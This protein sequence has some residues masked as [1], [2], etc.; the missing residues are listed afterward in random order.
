[1]CK[2]LCHLLYLAVALRL[3]M[4][5]AVCRVRAQLHEVPS[6]G[7]CTGDST[8]HRQEQAGPGFVPS[9]TVCGLLSSV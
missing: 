9:H 4:E 3:G 7:L 8:F 5:L 2:L 6:D 1:M